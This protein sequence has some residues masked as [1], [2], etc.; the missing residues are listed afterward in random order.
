MNWDVFTPVS[1]TIGGALIGISASIVLLFNGRIAG[2]SGILGG[3][4]RTPSSELFSR[5]AF[6]AGLIVGGVILLF[7]YEEA[8]VFEGGRE[9]LAILIPAGLIVGFGTQLGSGCT[10]GHGVCGLSRLSF[11]SLIATMMF[12]GFGFATASS[13]GLIWGG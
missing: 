9:S 6:L 3:A 10:S 8:F 2:I 11:R 4:F 12:M 7:S 1:A 13:F 5:F